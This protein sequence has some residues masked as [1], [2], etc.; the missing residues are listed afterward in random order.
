[1]GGKYC[2]RGL[3]YSSITFP[4][5]IIYFSRIRVHSPVHSYNKTMFTSI[6]SNDPLND[7]KKM[8]VHLTYC[9]PWLTYILF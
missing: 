8:Y 3:V 1:M 4:T 6:K 5:K 7:Q 9:A 2:N